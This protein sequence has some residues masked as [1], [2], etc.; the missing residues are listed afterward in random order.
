MHLCV[1]N[2]S[3]NAVPIPLPADVNTVLDPET[4]DAGPVAGILDLAPRQSV[5]LTRTN[6]T[7][8]VSALSAPEFR[9]ELVLGEAEFILHDL[10]VLV[11]AGQMRRAGDDDWSALDGLQFASDCP[12]VKI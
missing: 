11:P 9:N 7:A 8:R 10:N 1:F 5:I 12:E 4:G 2:Q 3:G 6:A